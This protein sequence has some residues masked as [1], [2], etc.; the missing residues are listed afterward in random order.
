MLTN[1]HEFPLNR[2]SVD[3]TGS[4]EEGYSVVVY[5]GIFPSCHQSLIQ[6]LPYR[7]NIIQSEYSE[8]I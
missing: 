4:S 3:Y 2:A 8:Y 1:I 6:G 7:S 5:D